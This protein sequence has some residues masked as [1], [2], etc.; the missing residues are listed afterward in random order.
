MKH[1][2]EISPR[3][4]LYFRDGRPLGGAADGNGAQWPLPSVLHSAVLSAFHRAFRDEEIRAYAKRHEHSRRPGK[5]RNFEQKKRTKAVFGGV[6]TLGPFPRRD[7]QI[8]F[9]VPADLVLDEGNGDAPAQLLPT[10]LPADAIGDLPPPLKYALWKNV[11]PSK[12]EL[13]QWISA[14]GLALYLSGKDKINELGAHLAKNDAFFDTEARP[15]IGIDAD[16]GTT[17]DGAFYLAEYLRL[18]PGVNM[19]ASLDALSVGG[20]GTTDLWEK[21]LDKNADAAFIFGGQRGVVRADTTAKTLD[22]PASPAEFPGNRVKWT[23]LSPALFKGFPPKKSEEDAEKDESDA[24][25]NKLKGAGWLPGFLDKDGNVMLKAV[26][27]RDADESREAWRER[28]KTAP[29]ISARLVAARVG[30]AIP[31][32]GWK[33]N[34]DENAKNS[35]NDGGGAPKATRLLVPAG[36]VYYFECESADDARALASALH[37]RVKSDLLGEQ[38]FGLGV[39]SAWELNPEK[40]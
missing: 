19:V 18:K 40:L 1:F 26:P 29:S 4:V 30:K 33:I 8:W 27:A 14:E 5:D 16:T 20:N 38:G 35:G 3:D 32:S 34:S 11:K 37:G 2:L 23:L 25:E 12:K 21:F 24:K 7:G 10:E 22:L 39:C 9:P 31:T 17:R 15:G 6:K 13:G 28:C 36:S